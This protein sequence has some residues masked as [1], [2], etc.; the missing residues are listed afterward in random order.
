MRHAWMIAVLM[1]L[2]LG[3]GI[4]EEE[5]QQQI[6]RERWWNSLTPEQQVRVESA[7]LQALGLLMQNGGPFGQNAML[8]PVPPISTAPTSRRCTS[9]VVSGSIYT[10]C[11]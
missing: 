1:T 3:C 9:N 11:N 5:R 7:R 10:T 4:S 8:A 6:A 2:C